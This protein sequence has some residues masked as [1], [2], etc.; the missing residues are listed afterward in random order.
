MTTKERQRRRGR[1]HWHLSSREGQVIMFVTTLLVAAIAIIL[2]INDPV[3]WGF[4]GTSIGI[5]I[6]WAIEKH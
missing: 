1:P 3:V 2:R 5:A 6:G 4:L